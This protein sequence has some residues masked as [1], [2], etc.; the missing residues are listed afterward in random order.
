MLAAG[1]LSGLV[2]YLLNDVLPWFLMGIWFAFGIGAALLLANVGVGGYSL[3]RRM[4]CLV[5]LASIPPLTLLSLFIFSRWLQQPLGET[6]LNIH[7]RDYSVN[8]FVALLL[9]L[10]FSA[11]LMNSALA[12][13]VNRWHAWFTLHFFFAGLATTG[14]V[15]VF[16]LVTPEKVGPLSRDAILTGALIVILEAVYAMIFGAGL[17]NFGPQQRQLA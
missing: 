11:V 4:V 9:S 2:T 3:K 5:L 15:L 8:F 16:Q 12:A 14:L 7:G 1:A 6:L 17:F 13:L 10:L